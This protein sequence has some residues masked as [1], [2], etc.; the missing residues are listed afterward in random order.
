MKRLYKVPQGCDAGVIH[1]TV[2]PPKAGTGVKGN[3]R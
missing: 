3:R 2:P 1:I